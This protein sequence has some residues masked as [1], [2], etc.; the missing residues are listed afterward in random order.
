MKEHTSGNISLGMFISSAS[1]YF[2][3]KNL[4]KGK[5]TYFG[6][7]HSVDPSWNIDVEETYWKSLL[8]MLE[9]I[10]IMDFPNC[11]STNKIHL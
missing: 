7:F 2:V 5:T 3:K 11:L 10:Q 4:R 9:N 1:K 8:K 6:L